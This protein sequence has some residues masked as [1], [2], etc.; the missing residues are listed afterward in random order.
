MRTQGRDIRGKAGEGR[1]EVPPGRG[2]ASPP[3][4]LRDGGAEPWSQEA[5]VPIPT[6][7]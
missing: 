2:L 1:V 5:A 6:R 4:G 7:P 3:L